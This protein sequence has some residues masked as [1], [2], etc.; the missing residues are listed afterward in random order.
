MVH[1]GTVG[2]EEVHE[3]YICLWCMILHKW[4]IVA[5][6]T[7]FPSNPFVIRVPLFLM[8]SLKKETPTGV[9]KPKPLVLTYLKSSRGAVQRPLWLQLGQGQGTDVLRKVLTKSAHMS[10]RL[11]CICIC[12]HICIYLCVYR[13]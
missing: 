4:K 6:K 8:F 10:G 3:D 9:P 13:V 11:V 5:L 2:F 1:S 7:W 12:I